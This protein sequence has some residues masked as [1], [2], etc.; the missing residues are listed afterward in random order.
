MR[1]FKGISYGKGL[2]LLLQSS[3]TFVDRLSVIMCRNSTS[4]SSH[5]VPPDYLL[6]AAWTFFEVGR[7]SLWR[8]GPRSGCSSE[9]SWKVL[10]RRWLIS[11]DL[12][13]L[14]PPQYGRRLLQFGLHRLSDWQL[15]VLLLSLSQVDWGVP[16]VPEFL[17]AVRWLLISNVFVLIPELH[18]FFFNL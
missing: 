11:A 8:F 4:L 3:E 12:F 15:R 16:R 17:K 7:A 18:L 1:T 13:L 2:S 6:E 10:S 14:L 5:R 9:Q